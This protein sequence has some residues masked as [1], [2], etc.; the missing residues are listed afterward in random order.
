MAGSSWIVAGLREAVEGSMR[1]DLVVADRFVVGIVDLGRATAVVADMVVAVA[2][3][4]VA[5]AA[6]GSLL[7]AAWG[8]RC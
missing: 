2:G 8:S 7:E 5:G 1:L 6:G 3:K 4:T